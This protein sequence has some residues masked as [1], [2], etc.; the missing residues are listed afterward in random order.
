MLSFSEGKIM[1]RVEIKKKTKFAAIFR[2]FRLGPCQLKNRLIALPVYTGYAY[3]DGRVSPQLIEHYTQLAQSGAAMVVVANAAVAADGIT[4]TYNL[5][6]D[7][8]AYIPGLARLAAAIKQGGAISCLQLNHGGRFAKSQKPLLPSPADTSNLVFNLEALKEFMNFFPLEKRFRLTH[9]FLKQANKWRRGITAE[10]MKRIIASFG[11]AAARAAAAGFDAIELHGANGY[12]LCGFLSPF[13]NRINDGFGGGFQNRTEFPLAVLREVQHRLPACFPIGFRLMLREWVPGG[14]DLPEALAFAGLL[15]NAGITYLSG[16][17]GS[18]NSIFLKEVM[19]KMARPAYLRKD[20]MQLSREV[21]VAT[22]IS[23]RIIKPALANALLEEKAADLIGLGRSLRADPHWIEKAAA[24]NPKTLHCTNCNWCLKR[25]VLEQGYSCRRWPRLIQQRTDLNHRLLT[26]N[27]RGLWVVADADDL[28]RFKKALPVFLPRS[29]QHPVPLSPTILFLQ[30]ENGRQLSNSD[31]EA[32]LKW[33]RK[34][35]NRCGFVAGPVNQVVKSA[36][37]A[38]DK[39]VHSEIKRGGYGVILIGRNRRQPWRE[40][41]LYQLRGKVIALLGTGERQNRILVPIDLSDN[42]LLV[43]T[44]LRRLYLGR[45]GL[46][47]SFLHVLNGPQK[48]VDHRWRESKRITALD[49]NIELQCVARDGEI[50]ATILQYVKAGNYGTIVMGKRG[51]SG[52][53]RWL[54]GSVSTGVLR[55][56]TEQS[57]FL[58]D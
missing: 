54:L 57:L 38:L 36:K 26:R 40:R 10:D 23:G 55:G 7:R 50:S 25:V 8:N 46:N 39:E 11:D 14:I 43:L 42:T 29:Q 3:P 18:F 20:M 58:I 6:V 41:L 1:D 13:T 56:L 33:S 44:F 16:S 34:T 19:K 30:T 2:P 17:V 53:K 24:Q 12:L 32:F 35:L 4:S 48:A 37:E 27:D 45:S 15:D 21:G 47:L 52:I 49:E 51:Y 5:R 22:I 9:F 28:K 31:R